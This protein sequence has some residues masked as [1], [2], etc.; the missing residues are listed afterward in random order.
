MTENPWDASWLRLGNCYDSG[1]REIWVRY[2][3]DG[4]V[5][6]TQHVYRVSTWWRP[7]DV[8]RVFWVVSNSRTPGGPSG[9]AWT[10]ARAKRAVERAM[11]AVS[12]RA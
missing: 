8:V 1:E 9:W 6:V 12:V 3:F 2:A 4:A 10:T 11:A 5:L 7:W